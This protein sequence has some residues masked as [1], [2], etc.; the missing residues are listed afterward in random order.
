MHKATPTDMKERTKTFYEMDLKDG[1]KIQFIFDPKITAKIVSERTVLFDGKEWNMTP[2]MQ[3]L[4]TRTKQKTTY[5]SGF[6]VFKFD[7][8]DPTLYVRWY[9]IQDQKRK[10]E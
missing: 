9:R 10:A 7:D 4:C 6:E 3:E 1:D 5:G 2:L 8:K